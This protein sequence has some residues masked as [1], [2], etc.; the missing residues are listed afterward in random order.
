MSSLMRTITIPALALL[1][2]CPA[3]TPPPPPAQPVQ[4]QQPA[5]EPAAEPAEPPA[6]VGK[7]DSALASKDLIPRSILF[8][9]PT[10]AGAQLSAD[11]KHLSFLAPVDG[12][13]NVWVG[14]VGD[15]AAAKPVTADKKR[16]IRRYFW[17]F[18]NK[19]VIYSQDKDGDENWHVYSVDLDSDQVKDLTPFE[20]VAARISKV[21][22]KRPNE[23]VVGINNRDKRWHDLYMVDLRTGESKL[24]LQNDDGFAG[25]IIDD[26]LN[27]VLA[28]KLTADGGG[29]IYKRNKKTKKW[30]SFI[31]YG[32][33]DSMTTSPVGLDRTGRNL[34]MIDSRGRNTAA[35]ASVN[36]RTGKEKV[37]FEND[38]ADVS[39][40]MVQPKRKTVQAVASN[41]T[42]VT[43]KIL[44]K[45]IARDLKYL[46]TVADGDVNVVDR[47]LD[48]K[49]WIVLY[50]M[51]VKPPSYYLYDRRKKKATFL[52]SVRPEAEGLPY[53]KMH[54]VVIKS[55]DGLDLVSYLTLPL[56]SDPQGTGRPSEPVPMVLFVHGGPWGRDSWGPNPYHQWMA[57]RGY[58]VLSVNFRGSTGF[59]KNFVNAG[60]HEW[61]GKMHD[62]LL[63]AVK[64]A[65]GEKITTVDKISIMGGSY[66]GYATLVGLTFTPE[67]FACGVDIVGPSNLETLLSTIPPYWTAMF[68]DLAR[69]VGDPRTEEGKALLKSR[70]PLFK[71]GEIERP[72]LIGQGAND[73][74]VKRAE[75]DRIVAAMNEKKIPVTY[76]LYPDE[77]HGFARPENRLSFNA[78]TEAFLSDCLGGKYQPV[79]NDFAG[80][81]I[82][83]VQGA[84]YVSGLTAALEAAKK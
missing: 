52:F 14:P 33:E 49:T 16:G 29:E 65:I 64:W 67:T 5:A 7:P 74:R 1:L 56:A 73:P 72:L 6:P 24:L 35:L 76:V 42:R 57:N 12:V 4:P 25:F 31:K 19:H 77:G 30:E 28:Q 41:F 22:W 60:N 37:L 81:S 44:D 34:Y 71:A 21:S 82:Q 18:D 20:G 3:S 75:P 11:G 79:G 2:G 10:R 39:G 63:D 55:R 68:N 50:T 8:G 51:D 23:I 53:S 38:R 69:R 70:S 61:A 78:V 32:G 54:P 9:N 46:A 59:G 83:V 36:I 84:E 47:T 17:A 13:L 58:A 27:P 45:S 48:D 62:D 40:A 15:L 80:S 43:W 66:G 26:K